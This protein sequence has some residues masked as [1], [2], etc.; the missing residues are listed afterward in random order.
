M[1]NHMNSRNADS[2]VIMID[3]ET[4]QRSNIMKLKSL[5]DDKKKIK[6]IIKLLTKTFTL[7]KEKSKD[8]S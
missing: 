4:S 6:S 1:I 7:K 8:H 5:R 2:N 3:V